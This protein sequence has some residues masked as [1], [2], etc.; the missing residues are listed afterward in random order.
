MS[1]SHALYDEIGQGYHQYPQPDPRIRAM[2]NDQ[3]RGNQ[4]SS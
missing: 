4:P 3:V 1:P 2:I